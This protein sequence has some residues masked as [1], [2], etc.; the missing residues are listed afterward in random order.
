M[1]QH[2]QSLLFA[3]ARHG[4]TNEQ[5]AEAITVVLP[6]LRPAMNPDNLNYLL[7]SAKCQQDVARC[8]LLYLLPQFADNREPMRNP[9]AYIG[10]A[11]HM[12]AADM[13]SHAAAALNAMVEQANPATQLISRDVIQ[14]LC[15]AGKKNPELCCFVAC[16]FVAK[17]P[18]AWLI[19]LEGWDARDAVRSGISKIMKANI[20]ICLTYLH[21][22]NKFP[23][24]AACLDGRCL[25]EVCQP[26]VSCRAALEAL[27]SLADLGEEWLKQ[28][29]NPPAALHYV[30]RHFI[31]QHMNEEQSGVLVDHRYGLLPKATTALAA[32]GNVYV[33][34]GQ[35]PEYNLFHVN[36]GQQI[37]NTLHC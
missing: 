31:Q 29:D 18:S 20:S 28:V 11:L 24:M 6:S 4:A 32:D 22:Q 30:L 1:I 26:G 8:F 15:H 9:A 19:N 10:C 16:E 35:P 25:L 3:A 34:I 23:T 33:S 17:L 13:P 36:N 12:F 14:T 2:A 37:R 21:L 7:F 5:L 27:H